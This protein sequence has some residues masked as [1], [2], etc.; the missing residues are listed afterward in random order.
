MTLLSF[1]KQALSNKDQKTI[2]L[3]CPLL[4]VAD[5]ASI[6]HAPMID[7]L[8]SRIDFVK[9]I[10]GEKQWSGSVI[11]VD[12]EGQNESL[13]IYC[14]RPEILYGA[15]FIALAPDHALAK[16]IATAE[17]HVAVSHFITHKLNQS[18]YYR[19]MNSTN[20]ALFT[21]AYGIN[22]LTKERLPIYISDYAIE[23]FDMRHSKTRIAIPAHN[24]K[25][26]E[27]ARTYNLP[28]KIVVDIQNHLQGK[29]DDMGPVV[30]APL[31]DK[32]GNLTE[33]YL[34]EYAQCI[35]VNSDV[36]NNASLKDAASYVIDHLQ[37]HRAGYAHTETLLYTYNN[38]LY[39]IK[40]LTRLEA[41]LHKNIAETK[42]VQ[43]LKEEL[44]I[45]LNYIQADFL[46]LAERFLINV[47][48]TKSLMVVLIEEDCQ[49]RNNNDCY[50]LKWAHLEGD[51]NEKDAFRRDITSIRNFTLFCKDLVNFLG[52]FAHSCPKALENIRN[53]NN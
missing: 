10:Q 7:I 47:K 13:T 9:L 23:C 45:A 25:D 28:I 43:E 3:N 48:N 32:Q 50:L 6:F 14:R 27:I 19:Q 22:P 15:T 30:A 5:N 52:D 38:Q 36:L 4:R 35:V 18:L 11:F 17:H 29:K 2:S 37:D 51:F 16:T 44:L 49:I 1:D 12:I 46:D 33:A 26:L 41:A 42:Q 34:G 21:G 39:S 8:Q 31:L 20:E 53:Q 40:D 24:S